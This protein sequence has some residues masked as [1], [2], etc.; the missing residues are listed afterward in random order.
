MSS[1]DFR[2]P[3][4]KSTV[5]NRA[6][7]LEAL[8]TLYLHPTG[9]VSLFCA[10]DGCPDARLETTESPPLVLV[11]RGRVTTSTVG[12]AF[13]GSSPTFL[14]SAGL[15][16]CRSSFQNCTR[17]YKRKATPKPFRTVNS[18]TAICSS[19]CAGAVPSTNVH[20]LRQPYKVICDVGSVV[21]DTGHS[22]Y[23]P[24][25]LIRCCASQR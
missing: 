17:T 23:A 8:S 12:F 7:Y 11:E 14:M 9:C 13:A 10:G 18:S 16:E 4:D 22:S 6:A 1:I 5:L 2:A 20:V 24:A 3:S 15:F 25:D 19:W 21:C